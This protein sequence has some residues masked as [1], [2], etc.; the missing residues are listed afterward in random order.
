MKH[1]YP[2]AENRLERLYWERCRAS[3]RIQH[4]GQQPW[5]IS[6]TIPAAYL[7]WNS[8][9]FFLAKYTLQISCL[10]FLSSR[11]ARSEFWN[12]SKTERSSKWVSIPQTTL[13]KHF[14]PTL[15]IRTL[16]SWAFGIIHA[17]ACWN[18]ITSLNCSSSSLLSYFNKILLFLIRWY[19]TVFSDDA[20]L[21]QP[22]TS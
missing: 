9:A 15:K 5:A 10:T 18:S 8:S 21:F 3:L 14:Q 20:S 22:L 16:A 1:R 7:Q 17:H 19:E 6:P 13:W 12:N 2:Q 4:F 11:Q